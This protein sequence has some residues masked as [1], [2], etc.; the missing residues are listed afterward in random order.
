MSRARVHHCRVRRRGLLNIAIDVGLDV[1]Y[2]M[3]DNHKVGHH[4]YRTGTR[5][6]NMQ[7][8]SKEHG[9]GHCFLCFR[10]TFRVAFVL[11]LP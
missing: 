4:S 3:A 7:G 1:P 2:T 6:G 9:Y 11:L 8:T 10:L 5:S